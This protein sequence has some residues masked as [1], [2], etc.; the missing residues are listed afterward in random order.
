MS[1]RP[2]TNMASEVAILKTKAAAKKGLGTT[3]ADTET[4]WP[5]PEWASL[6]LSSIFRVVG[7]GGWGA[8]GLGR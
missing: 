4:I 2:A 5:K 7:V 3:P 1:A 8:D 6:Y